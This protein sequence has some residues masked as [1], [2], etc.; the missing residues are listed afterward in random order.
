LGARGRTGI[1]IAVVFGVASLA[2]LGS[3]WNDFAWDDSFILE[4]NG[5]VL[6]GDPVAAV[7]APFWPRQLTVEGGGL[8]RPLVSGSFALE[9]RAWGRSPFPFHLVNV[10]GHG[11]VSVLVLLLAFSLSGKMR[12][13]VAGG[14]IF[15][16]HPVHVEAV[17]NVVGRAEIMAALFYLSGC[18]LFLLLRDTECW[19]RRLP[20]IIGI[21]ACYFLSLASKEIGV[22][23]PVMLALLAV[24]GGGRMRPDSSAPRRSAWAG[25]GAEAPLF[26]LLGGVFAAYMGIR[27][28]VVGSFTGEV[29]A[30]E[31]IGISGLER[32]WTGLSLW[33]DYLRLL[34]VPLDLSADYG[35]A[36]RFPAHGLDALVFTGAA[37]V[38]ALLA[39]AWRARRQAPLVT[40]GIGWI[41][42]AVL[43]VANLVILAGILLAERTLYLPSVALSLAVAALLVNLP[44]RRR[45]RVG[46]LA[47]LS[48]V[49]LLFTVRTV[50]RV[51]VWKDTP[52]V[53]QSLADT[54]PES[55]LVIRQEAFRAMTAGNSMVATDRFERA[56]GLVPFHF[57]LLTEAA[58]YY[59]LRG[60]YGRAEELLDRAADVYPTSPYPHSIRARQRLRRGEIESARDAALE[61]IRKAEPLAPLWEVLEEIRAAAPPST[62]PSG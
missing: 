15:A 39:V 52:A 40:V 27:L 59:G 57:S 36:V 5:P 13:G 47:A 28:S 61:G 26:L 55:H 25:L 45:A 62:T 6:A 4:S 43:P 11:L 3:L 53:L 54:H 22:T 44:D 56:L 10:L 34:L 16:V 42:I 51:P 2:Y 31:M 38:L 20:L 9:W 14:L 8:Y 50:I 33:P 29:V 24:F 48:V 17:A 58:Q 12:A 46:A 32:V 35:P 30:P 37:M 41:L 60:A 19:R 23:L 18:L 21:G 1:A 7:Q 49:C